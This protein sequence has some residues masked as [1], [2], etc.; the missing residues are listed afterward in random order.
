MSL[1]QAS[2]PPPLLWLLI[3]PVLPEHLSLPPPLLLLLQLP[4]PLLLPGLHERWEGS[5]QGAPSPGIG[6][7]G[8]R[9]HWCRPGCARGTCRRGQ[10]GFMMALSPS[11]GSSKHPPNAH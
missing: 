7:A 10:E 1:P 4:L 6:T 11:W 8:A 9:P 3:A 2:P 5:S